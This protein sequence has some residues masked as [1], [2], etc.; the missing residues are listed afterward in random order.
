MIIHQLSVSFKF[1]AA[2]QKNLLRGVMIRGIP[3]WRQHGISQSS[4]F[5]PKKMAYE[6]EIT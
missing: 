5:L 2:R 4:I 3:S 6:L 1:Y